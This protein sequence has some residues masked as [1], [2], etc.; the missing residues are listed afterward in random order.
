MKMVDCSGNSAANTKAWPSDGCG[1][2]SGPAIVRR[3]RGPR[4]RG[5]P[6]VGV[7]ATIPARHDTA[8]GIGILE[9]MAP[10]NHQ[11]VTGCVVRSVGR[12]NET[13]RI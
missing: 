11:L 7:N 2:V 12:R 5:I 10:P 6:N 3:A 1:S 8:P 4:P 9:G 13:I